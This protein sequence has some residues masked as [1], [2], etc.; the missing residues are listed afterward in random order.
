[1][2]YDAL[3]RLLSAASPMFGNGATGMAAYRYD[4]LDNLTH[5]SM[6][7]TATNAGRD[8]YYCY[9]TSWRLTNLKTG[10]CDGA[11]EVGLGYDAQ[12]N[13]ANKK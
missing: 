2:T 9:D 11:T 12:G 3:D 5:L 8:W 1:M 6:P 10:S 4:V 13:L 7:A